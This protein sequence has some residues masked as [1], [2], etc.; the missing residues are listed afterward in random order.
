MK[1]KKIV[2]EE[3]DPNNPAITR[4]K[5]GHATFLRS[6]LGDVLEE[7]PGVISV[8][9]EDD[10][11]LIVVYKDGGQCHVTITEG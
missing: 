8:D 3:I 6:Q 9:S 7:L 4:S 10:Q 5:M 11:T 1:W 2:K